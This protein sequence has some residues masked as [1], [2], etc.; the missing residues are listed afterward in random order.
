VKKKYTPFPPAQTPSKIDLALESGEYFASAAEKEAARRAKRMTKA[1]E[2]HV[3]RAS[4]RARA[5]QAPAE[6]PHP[7]QPASHHDDP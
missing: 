6:A 1:D 2:S 7:R 4:K 3:E 5:F